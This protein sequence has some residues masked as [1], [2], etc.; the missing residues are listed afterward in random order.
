MS[1]TKH[2]LNCENLHNINV[3]SMREIAYSIFDRLSDEQ[4]EGF[5][6]M[7]GNSSEKQNM[8]RNETLKVLDDVRNG[9][10]MSASFSSVK[11]LMED[12][13]ADD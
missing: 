7:F 3:F 4:I 12:L 8:H 11:E 2:P 9:K 10:N 13:N 5:I 6:L 1:N